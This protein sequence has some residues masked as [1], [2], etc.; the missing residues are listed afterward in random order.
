MFPAVR[1]TGQSQDDWN[2][3]GHRLLLRAEL[4]SVFAIN[5]TPGGAK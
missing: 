2:V 5:R 4:A 3:T 1:R